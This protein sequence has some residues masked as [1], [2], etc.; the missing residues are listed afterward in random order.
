MKVSKRVPVDKMIEVFEDKLKSLN[1]SQAI[2]CSMY[3]DYDGSFGEPGSV[4]S[5]DDIKKYWDENHTDDPVLLDYDSYEDWRKDTA[6]LLHEIDED[7]LH[8]L[9]EKYNSSTPVSGDWQT[10]TAAEQE[11][12]ANEFNI[13]LP[14]AKRLMIELLG[15]DIDD[16]FVNASTNIHASWEGEDPEITDSEEYIKLDSKQVQDSDGFYT[17]YTL[18]KASDGSVYFCMF[19]DSDLYEPNPEYADAEFDNEEEAY[20]W[21]EDYEGF[22][23]EEEWE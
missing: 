2:K 15:F 20:E 6:W 13:S 8:D 16:Y 9:I 3:A 21:F 5:D 10:E 19:G 18:Y 14:A 4:V 23:E 1:S 12:I 17:D 22:V 11:D 7:R